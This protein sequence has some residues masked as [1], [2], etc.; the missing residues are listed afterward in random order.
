M[1]FSPRPRTRRFTISFLGLF[2]RPDE[3][4]AKFW[5]LGMSVAGIVRLR[6]TADSAERST[7]LLVDAGLDHAGDADDRFVEGTDQALRG[8]LDRAEQARAHDV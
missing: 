4:A 5:S 3:P 7:F 2:F 8:A 6:E 1:S